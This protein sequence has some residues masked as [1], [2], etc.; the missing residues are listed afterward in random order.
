MMDGKLLDLNVIFHEA[1]HVLA[2]GVYS[3][4]PFQRPVHELHEADLP[5]VV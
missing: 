4:L 1:E 2:H 3:E 5:V